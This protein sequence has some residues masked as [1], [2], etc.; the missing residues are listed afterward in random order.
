VQINLKLN[1][2]YL[3]LIVVAALH[4]P[5]AFAEAQQ[6]ASEQDLATIGQ[7]EH[8]SDDFTNQD[9]DVNTETHSTERHQ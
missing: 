6:D 9:E 2:S 8:V 5:R 1:Y 7:V 4:A 3:A